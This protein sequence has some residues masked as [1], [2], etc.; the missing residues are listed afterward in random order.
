MQK[1][2][3]II[4]LT[5]S[6]SFI[7][8]FGQ[9]NNTLIQNAVNSTAAK[10]PDAAALF[11][12]TEIPVSLYT[13]IPEI[14]IPLYTIKE[15]DIELPVSISYH[16]GGIKVNDEASSIGLGWNLN[17][18]GRISHVVAGANDFSLH[19][20]YNTYPK[21]AT[22][23][24]GSVSICPVLPWNTSTQT[25]AF[26]S[27]YFLPYESDYGNIYID[28][29]FQP[30]Q[31]LINLPNKSY[32]AYLDM[33]KTIK[34]DYPKF[35]IA[36]QPNVNFKL[37]PA[38]GFQPGAYGNYKF[39]VTD[40][41]GT[42]YYF[43][44]GELSRPMVGGNSISGLSQLLT[45]IEDIKGNLVN[46]YYSTSIINDR[47]SGCKNTRTDYTYNPN[48][49][50]GWSKEN[51]LTECS[52]LR[53]DESFIEKIEFSNGK[54]EFIWSERED[55]S[56]SKKLTSIK[57]Y[58]KYKLIRQFDFNY[59]YFIAA[60]NL[61]T[62][63]LVQWLGASNN[64]IFTH[65]LRLL[66]LTESIKNEKYSFEYNS[67]YN[68]PNKLSFSTDFWGYYNGQ[69]NSDTFIPNP[70][71]YIKGENVFNVTSFT[72]DYLG[73]WY[74]TNGAPPGYNPV[75][76]SRIFKNFS[77]DGKHYLSD[78]RA[79][80][81]S[82]AN[83]LTAINYPTGGKTE[84]EYEPN[85]FSN[86]PMQS[87]LN[88]NTRQELNSYQNINIINGNTIHS[89]GVNDFNV[90]GSNIKLNIRAKFDFY[91]LSNTN[92]VTQS[93]WI[94]IKDK[95]TGQIIKQIYNPN[96]G[97][98]QG[99]EVNENIILQSGNYEIGTSYN[100]NFTAGNIG[101][102]NN[103]FSSINN[104]YHIDYVNEKSIINNIEHNY[105]SGGGIRIKSIKSTEKPG[106]TPIIKNYIYDEISN[107]GT[108]ITSYGNLAD[109]PKFFEI[110]NRCYNYNNSSASG[111]SL[112][113]NPGCYMGLN[114]PQSP[115]NYPLKISVYEGTPGQGTS[116]LPQ[117][118]H[119]GYSKVIEQETGKG[120]T[121]SYFVNYYNQSCIMMA[122]RGTSL[123][124]GDGDITKQSIYDNSNNLIKETVYK[125]KFNYPDNLNTYFIPASIL[126]PITSFEPTFRQMNQ[127]GVTASFG[128]II[129]NYS[130]NLY[131]SL[132]ESTTT[133]EYFP[134][135]SNNYIETKTLTTYNTK[136][137]PS[138]Q[139][140]TYPDNSFTE[141][142]YNYAQEKGNQL[143]IGKNM[144][145]IPLE[146]IVTQ[147]N[148]GIVKT[149]SKTETVYPISLPD[150]QI[151]NFTLPK[152]IKTYD[153]SNT[154]SAFTEVTLDKYDVKGN[155][156]QYTTKDGISITIIWG[157]NKTQPIAKIEGAKFADIPQSLIDSI[158]NASDNDSQVGTDISEQSLIDALDLF[159]NN[160]ALAGYQ[161][162]T[163]TYD[164]LIGVK[165]I[166]PP[167][168]IRE[169]YKYDSANRLEKVIDV[170][171]KVLKEYKYNY[172]N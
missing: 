20:Y 47:L 53:V 8:A 80:L 145:G 86:F 155:I 35:A 12:Y 156:Q 17:V 68:L 51:G 50:L 95:S 158:V 48:V 137:Q 98:Y 36:G 62:S 79:S 56:N 132:L 63:S 55:V 46:F 43:D 104:T 13:G 122:Q 94:Y 150:S 157:Y 123:I 101:L 105:S 18:G 10:S 70:E 168:G 106:S 111:G 14:S 45:K 117:G 58:N 2:K 149:L 110:E 52:K 72:K 91:F 24:G 159:R 49:N 160:S 163:Y 71:K 59:D 90:I 141:T 60:D 97:S 118:N 108:K 39:Q 11:R 131:K 125:Y 19:G 127:T 172:K 99:T 61:D 129:H 4:F 109:F 28:N 102:S 27:N 103:S 120:R 128:G 25:N 140:N 93:F 164:P 113:A 136:Y 130:I 124:I 154:T 22:G 31:F 9:A 167:S 15:G 32:K 7:I 21:N 38:S 151:G 170:N 166:T 74:Q 69:N 1:I 82:L 162:S 76:D 135:G 77:P 37:I 26:Y 57:I 165:S 88:D 148:N 153:I 114:T 119:I 73:Y 139:K 75:D 92:T 146:T 152:S 41:S 84:Y 138:I 83:M 81:Y 3:K 30:D 54:I 169:V 147:T 144:V 116:T 96:I 66:N 42:N 16:A 171:G 115:N 34:T 126:E 112:L 64:K 143:L 100:S 89:G 161:I 29:D 65:R 23:S 5:S 133:K 33:S 85:T 107:N 6:L 134:T 40:E 67:T 78:R 87:L 121:E 142:T 44:K